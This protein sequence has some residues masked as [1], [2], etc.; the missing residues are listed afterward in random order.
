MVLIHLQEMHDRVGPGSVVYEN[1]NRPIF[2]NSLV[3]QP[4][5]VL[6]VTEI[7]SYSQSLSPKGFDIR[8]HRIN[9]FNAPSGD[10]DS[11]AFSRQSFRNAPSDSPTGSSDNSNLLKKQHSVPP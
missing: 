9:A 6:T 2:L 1:I 5:H 11:S 8:H 7:G 4:M 3:E 10:H